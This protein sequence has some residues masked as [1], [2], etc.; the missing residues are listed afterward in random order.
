MAIAG[1]AAAVGV[2]YAH[3]VS[4]RLTEPSGPIQLAT[5][6]NRSPSRGS[7]R[8]ATGSYSSPANPSRVAAAA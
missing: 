1:K 5:M 7:E 3:A 4:G 2:R 8:S 6:W